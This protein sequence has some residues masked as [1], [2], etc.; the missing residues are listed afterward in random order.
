MIATTLITGLPGAGKSRLI[1]AWRESAPA[2]RPSAVLLNGAPAL[3]PM[4]SGA[5]FERLRAPRVG[6]RRPQQARGAQSSDS[7]WLET[8]SG[9][10]C[11]TARAALPAAVSRLLKRGPWSDLLIELNGA[12]HPAAFIDL[13]RSP[14]LQT[15]LWLASV[16]AVV[17]ASLM[18]A[19]SARTAELL[20]EQID[21]ADRIWVRGSPQPGGPSTPLSPD[22]GPDRFLSFREFNDTPESWWSDAPPPRPSS[23]EPSRVSLIRRSERGWC[24]QSPASHIHDRSALADVLRRAHEAVRFERLAAAFRTEREWYAWIG[25]PGVDPN[26]CWRPTLFRSSNRIDIEL[27]ENGP[28]S[29]EAGERLERWT[30]E[31]AGCR[32]GGP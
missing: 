31:I 29:D 2:D 11:C 17:D 13:L 3:F 7:P 25:A 26:E 24:W 20:G 12:A 4:M 18:P 1:E 22:V 32:I 16:I 15:H 27:A 28:L 23:P 30:D 9:C 21:T 5:G 8:L 14:V 6:Q 19:T 10:L